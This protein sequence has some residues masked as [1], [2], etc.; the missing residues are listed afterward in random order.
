VKILISIPKNFSDI[1]LYFKFSLDI[2]ARIQYNI[3]IPNSEIE[4]VSMW[5]GAHSAGLFSK[6]FSEKYGLSLKHFKIDWYKEEEP[7]F[8]KNGSY[9]MYNVLAGKNNNTKMIEYVR[10]NGG[11]VIVLGDGKEI[12][13]ILKK[14][15][16]A[17]LEV[18]NGN[19]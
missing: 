11:A 14:A 2:I 18:Y 1:D 10:K 12:E 19:M 15:K 13:D 8:W 7:S 9:G 6:K 17:E 5:D 16:I 4:I 3:V